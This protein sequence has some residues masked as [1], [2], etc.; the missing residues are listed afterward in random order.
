MAEDNII[1]FNNRYKIKYSDIINDDGFLKLT[2]VN[3]LDA[4]GYEISESGVREF[5]SNNNLEVTGVIGVEDFTML[6]QVFD[7]DNIQDIVSHLDRSI[8]K[9]NKKNKK[10]AG[11][12]DI[13]IF[14]WLAFFAFFEVFGV[15]SFFKF[16]YNMVAH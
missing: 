10:N 3:A 11:S 13:K 2:A 9:Y 8:D 4:A 6:I 1:E 12:T 14:I 7:N 16:I 15:L 5:Q